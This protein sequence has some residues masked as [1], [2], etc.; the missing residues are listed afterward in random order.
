MLSNLLLTCLARCNSPFSYLQLKFWK[1]YAHEE[2]DLINSYTAEHAKELAKRNINS[3]F[4]QSA[5][6][7][8]K[9][10][11]KK[12]WEKIS[13]LYKFSTKDHYYSN[14]HRYVESHHD[15]EGGEMMRMGSVTSD[16]PEIAPAALAF[17]DDARIDP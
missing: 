8:V 2:N 16:G 11:S 13:S 4:N 7:P 10:P 9:T 12:D 17:I 3:F 1:A 14:L 5:P 6:E 15:T